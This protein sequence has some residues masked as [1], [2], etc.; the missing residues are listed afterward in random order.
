MEWRT[1]LHSHGL[2]VVAILVAILLG[3][4][5]A[6]ERYP[7]LLSSLAENLPLDP[8]FQLMRNIGALVLVF[9]I[10][11]YARGYRGWLPRVKAKLGS[12]RA[13]LTQS[14]VTTIEGCI[15]TN[16]TLW[17]GVARVVGGEATHIDVEYKVYCPKC[18]SLMYDG[19]RQSVPVAT[20][21]TTYWECPY[22][23]HQTIED[24]GKLDDAKN[25]FE[26][27]IRQI[28]ESEGEPYSLENL[29]ERIDGGV[30][31]QAIWEAYDEVSDLSHVSTRCFA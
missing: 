7:P 22:C 10:G 5:E 17:K 9:S 18:T 25:L 8:I 3:L 15:E 30:T 11:W 6:I 27:E 23:P 20:S 31:G 13:Y 19:E 16:G 2:Q 14:P 24:I 29:I 21:A 4:P 28:T 1:W 26:T 12:A